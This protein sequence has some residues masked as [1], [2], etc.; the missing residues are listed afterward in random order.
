MSRIQSAATTVV[1]ALAAAIGTCQPPPPGYR[2]PLRPAYSPYLNLTR[3]GASVTQNYFGMVRPELEARRSI[4]QLQQQYSAVAEQQAAF[5]EGE[6]RTT[7]HAVGFLTHSRY[8]GT[9][10]GGRLS[11]GGGASQGPATRAPASPRR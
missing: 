2:P 6:I 11:G 9:F 10:Q 4:G 5:S 8:F 3:P 7:G 1:A